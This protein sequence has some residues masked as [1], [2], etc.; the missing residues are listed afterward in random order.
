LVSSLAT[1][2]RIP[3]SLL[4]CPSRSCDGYAEQLALTGWRRSRI[5]GSR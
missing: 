2:C 1:T 3:S 4:I 5:L